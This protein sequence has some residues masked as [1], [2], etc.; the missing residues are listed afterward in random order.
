MH[1]THGGDRKRRKELFLRLVC[2]FS[3]P[4][5]A[6]FRREALAR[7]ASCP[8]LRAARARPVLPRTCLAW[9]ALGAFEGGSNLKS[10]GD[11]TARDAAGAE[12]LRGSLVSRVRLGCAV[13]HMHPLDHAGAAGGSLKVTGLFGAEWGTLPA[14]RLHVGHA[15]QANDQTRPLSSSPVEGSE[16]PFKVVRDCLQTVT[17]VIFPASGCGQRSSPGNLARRERSS[18]TTRPAA[19]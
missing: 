1:G 2:G 6:G 17:S 5:A 14:K 7:R 16:G 10:R 4:A 8:R 9:S 13:G 18:S 3:E 11:V 15:R 19:T 12:P